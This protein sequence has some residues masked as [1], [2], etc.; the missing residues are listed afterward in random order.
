MKFSCNQQIISKAFNIVSKAVTTRTTIPILNGILL[1]VD[2]DGYLTMSASDLE[3]GIEKT[4]K[5]ENCEEGEIVVQSKLFGDIIRKLPDAQIDFEVVDDNLCIKCRKSFFNIICSSSDEFPK[6]SKQEDDM[7]VL[8]LDKDIFRNMIKQTSFAASIDEARGVIT[9]VLFEFENEFLNMVALDGFRMAIAKSKIGVNETKKIIIPAKILNEISKIILESEF[10]DENE[11]NYIE[12]YVNKKRANFIIDNTKVYLRLLEG[13]FIDYQR[14]VPKDQKCSIKVN[15]NELLENIERASLFAK[16]G[17][18]NLIKFDI[19]NDYLE[20]TSKSEEG[21]VK[22]EILIDKKGDDLVIGFNSKYLIDCLKNVEDE[23]I[24]LLFNTSITP[25]LIKPLE[26][27]NF[28]Y[29]VL[30]VRITSS[31]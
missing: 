25:C 27:D 12:V 19:K 29:L 8:R 28:E 21:D 20:I 24:N 11:D 18:N 13:D 14:I 31:N 16:I 30:P 22:E 4:L 2:A 1:K 3:I 10:N 5:I 17:K 15:K 9:G 23:E 6:M 7:E 26:G